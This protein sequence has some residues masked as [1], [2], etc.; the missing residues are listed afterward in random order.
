MS[1][2]IKQMMEKLVNGKSPLSW[3]DRERIRAVMESKDAK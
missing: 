3:K 2:E 1:E